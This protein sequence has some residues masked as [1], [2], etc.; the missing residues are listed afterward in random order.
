MRDTT[1][2]MLDRSSSRADPLSDVLSLLKPRNVSCGAINAGD[3]CLAFPAGL[4]VKC[5]AVTAGEAW[6]AV[7]GVDAPVHLA[8]GDCF[9]LPHGRAYQLAS[10]LT[11]PPVD[12]R[13]VLAGRLP[14]RITVWNGGGRATIVSATF[15]IEARYAGILIDILPSIAHVGPDA[16][17]TALRGALFQMMEELGEPKPGSRLIVENL[18]TMV[19]TLALRAYAAQAG[20]D[21]VG[22]LFALADRQ[23]GLAIGAM[24]AEPAQRWTVRTLADHAGMSRT[25][26]ALRFKSHVGATPMNYLTRLRMLLAS[27]RL[28]HSGD[29][30]SIVAGALG[31][32]SESAFSNAFKRELGCSPRRFV[33]GSAGRA[34]G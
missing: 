2:F 28:L 24:H 33:N 13:A 29:A 15:L 4:G 22:W 25:S 26:F 7:E 30:I 23:I 6:L 16:D 14:G 1:S 21:Q 9:I 11:L 3:T 27:D 32:E 19:L 17:R 5:H 31:Y 8:T 10:D 20:D 12:Y 18:A 34:N